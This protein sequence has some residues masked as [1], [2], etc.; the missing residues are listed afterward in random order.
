MSV[1]Q[2]GMPTTCYSWTVGNKDGSCQ[3]STD[4][5]NQAAINLA[6][7]DYFTAATSHDPNQYRNW[8][9]PGSMNYCGSQPSDGALEN[10]LCG[11]T[12][13][14]ATAFNQTKLPNGRVPNITAINSW[15]YFDNVN[16]VPHYG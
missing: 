16:E 13:S 4:L 12:G 10:N 8:P 14:T 11:I 2:R 1:W 6:N 5:T 7:L 15:M 9:V 3:I